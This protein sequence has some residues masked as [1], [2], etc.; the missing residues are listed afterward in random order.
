MEPAYAF[1]RHPA[2]EKGPSTDLHFPSAA[3]AE[4]IFRVQPFAPVLREP[5]DAHVRPIL[6][7]RRAEEHHIALKR[8]TGTSKRQENSQ[9]PGRPLLHIHSAPA[10]HIPI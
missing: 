10:P 5:G 8:Y 7:V 4:A 9:M 2:R 1:L 3:L 6:F